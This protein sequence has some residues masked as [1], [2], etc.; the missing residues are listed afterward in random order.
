MVNYYIFLTAPCNKK[1]IFAVCPAGKFPKLFAHEITAR[2]KSLI[3][4]CIAN[5]RK[6]QEELYALF[7]RKLFGVACRYAGDKD[8]ANDLLQESFIRIFNKIGDYKGNGS[9]EGWMRRI[10]ASVSI[11]YLNKHYKNAFND[12]PIDDNLETN[13]ENEW[14]ETLDTEIIMNE[15]ML[16]PEGFRAV[17]NL[18]AIEGYSYAEIAQMLHIKEVTVRSQYLRAKQKLAEA[19]AKHQ[20]FSYAKKTI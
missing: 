18:Y 20:I 17:I 14:I 2:E 10:V 15:I 8:L 3:D 11:N 5:N 6:A 19:L 4:G 16:L 13:H 7:S 1:Q 12:C 9:F